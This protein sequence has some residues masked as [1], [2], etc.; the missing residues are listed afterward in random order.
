MLIVEKGAGTLRFEGD[1]SNIILRAGRSQ[2]R[3]DLYFYSPGGL[4]EIDPKAV[5]SSLP[6]QTYE[7]FPQEAGLVQLLESGAL[8]Q[9][10][11][12]EYVVQKKTRLPAGL[13]GAHSV[14]FLLLRGT[15][16]PD[17]TPVIP[18]S[19]SKIKPWQAS[20]SRAVNRQNASL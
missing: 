10:R 12:G 16:L 4:V 13:A 15:P 6:A 1:T 18:A 20:S 9:N 2:A 17:G 19:R 3:D 7:V 5:V 14:K 11:A 8:K